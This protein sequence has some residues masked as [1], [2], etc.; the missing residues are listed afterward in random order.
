[1]ILVPFVV[2]N[3]E[4]GNNVRIILYGQSSLMYGC[5]SFFF[6]VRVGVFNFF[7]FVGKCMSNGSKYFVFREW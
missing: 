6:V 3:S 4:Y 5:I 1:M 2:K 7:L